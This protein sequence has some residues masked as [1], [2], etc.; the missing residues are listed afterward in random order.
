MLINVLGLQS[1][2][3]KK[4]IVCYQVLDLKKDTLAKTKLKINK[5]KADP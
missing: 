1:F 2:I 3:F 5:T 4:G